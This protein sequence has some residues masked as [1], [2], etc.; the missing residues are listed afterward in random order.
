MTSSMHS[1]TMA[2]AA[3]CTDLRGAVSTIE[4]FRRSPQWSTF[5]HKMSEN[6]LH[7]V[8]PGQVFLDLLVQD[9]KITVSKIY[10]I[11][12]WIDANHASI[13]KGWEEARAAWMAPR[14]LTR[15]VYGSVNEKWLYA[16]L[17]TSDAFLHVNP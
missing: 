4:N 13:K 9:E 12:T 5:V 3:V 1:E 16:T 11:V 15:S 7:W 10:N 14:R 2:A 8:A 17:N 6:R